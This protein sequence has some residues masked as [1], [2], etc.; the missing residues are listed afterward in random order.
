MEVESEKRAG[1][2][3]QEGEGGE[4]GWVETCGVGDE[5]HVEENDKHTRG[6]QVTGGRED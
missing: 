3:R 6:T 1:E 4:G 5:G 2:G